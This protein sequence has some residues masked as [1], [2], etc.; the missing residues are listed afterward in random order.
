MLEEWKLWLNVLSARKKSV[1]PRRHG[2]WLEEKTKMAREPN[3]QLGFMNAAEN[4]SDQF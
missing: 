1:N 2:R 4:P 3:L